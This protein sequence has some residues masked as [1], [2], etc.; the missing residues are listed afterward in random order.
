M[1]D[2]TARYCV[3]MG[4]YWSNIAVFSN[5]ATVYLLGH[6]F[7]NTAI[8]MMTAAASLMAALVQPAL[9]AWADRPRSPSVRNILLM[10]TGLFL[11]SAALVP[12]TADRSMALLVLFYGAGIML[13]QCMMPLTNALGTLNNGDGRKV[14]FGIG[15]GTGSLLYAVFSV[16]IGQVT[17]KSGIALIP[18]AGAG[19]YILLALSLTAFPFKKTPVPRKKTRAGFF[20]RYPGFATVLFAAG[21]LYTSH[22]LIGNFAFQVIV[23]KGGDSASLGVSYAIA[24]LTELPVM[25]FFTRL[26]KKMSAGKW[27]IVSGFA[28]LIKCAGTLLVSSVAGYYGVQFLQLLAFA[29]ITVAS[30]HYVSGLMAPQDAVKGQAFFGVSSTAGTI[31]ASAL[32]GRLLDMSGVTA[33]LIAAVAFAAVSAAVMVWGVRKCRAA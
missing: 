32:G 24:A 16:L 13:M 14:D 18:I 10:L 23:S 31:A 30:V 12:L 6:G 11:L 8:G 5:Y 2:L 33:L 26:L 25:F 20:R 9:G 19:L 3:V 15:R 1:M 17:E 22:K 4:C 29:V 21:C 27:L 7:S 28:N